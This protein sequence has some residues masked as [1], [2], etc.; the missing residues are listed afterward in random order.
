M[1]KKPNQADVERVAL[2]FAKELIDTSN[3]WMSAGIDDKLIERATRLA[4]DWINGEELRHEI[5]EQTCA[6]WIDLSLV[7]EAHSLDLE[8]NKEYWFVASLIKIDGD[9]CEFPKVVKAKMLRRSPNFSSDGLKAVVQDS[10]LN[11]YIAQYFI[12]EEDGKEFHS[13]FRPELP[14]GVHFKGN[15][16]F[17]PDVVS[18]D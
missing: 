9:I 7:K 18:Q 1:T 5:V 2:E 4:I 17:S 11:E 15:G 13:D 6:N 10:E 16:N 14:Y 12:P 8:E 3:G